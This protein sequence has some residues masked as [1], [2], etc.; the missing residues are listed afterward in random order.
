MR[1]LPDFTKKSKTTLEIAI[2]MDVYAAHTACATKV[3]PKLTNGPV[4]TN[5]IGE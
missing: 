2:M 4:P 1:S 3:A 5:L